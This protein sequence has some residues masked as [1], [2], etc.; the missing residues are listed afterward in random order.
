MKY[1]ISLL[2]AL[3]L[4]VPLSPLYAKND[5]GNKHNGLPPG[6]Q[7]NME[8]GKPLPPGW[9]K[10]LHR[11]DILEADIYRHAKIVVPLDKHGLIT[12]SIEGQLLRLVKDTREIID[13]LKH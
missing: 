13:I 9:Q 4:L 6:L 12:V 2:T 1:S 10:K 7:K 5:K 3:S 8:R 11:G